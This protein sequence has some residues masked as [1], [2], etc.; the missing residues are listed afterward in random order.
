M[1]KNSFAPK[2]ARSR[3]SLERLMASAREILN[4]KGIEGATVPRVAARPASAPPR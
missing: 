4:E 1:R 2:Q 3:E